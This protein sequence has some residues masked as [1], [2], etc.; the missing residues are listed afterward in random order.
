MTTTT[1]APVLSAEA[2]ATILRGLGFRILTAEDLGP[3]VEVF[4]DAC[5]LGESLRVDRIVGPATTRVLKLAEKA[6]R[7]GRNTMSEH[8]DFREFA[9]GCGGEDRCRGVVVKG[10]LHDALRV[11]RAAQ[12]TDGLHV[13]SGY[14]C[15]AHNAR[16][17][18]AASL[19]QHQ[20][21]SGCDIQQRVKPSKVAALKVFSGIGY[22]ARNGL[23]CHVDVRGVG[24]PALRSQNPTGSTV[25]R[26]SIF[27]EA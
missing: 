4:Q 5:R 3:A 15:P 14:R 23:V 13:L 2:S 9:C 18:G 8:F 26:P 12:Y 21:G 24:A 19:S 25:T 10:A 22:K 16:I 27:A 17:A 7:E 1:D 11:L 6:S 20:W